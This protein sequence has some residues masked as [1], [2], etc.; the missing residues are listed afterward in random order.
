M[1]DVNATE[2]TAI[3]TA[4]TQTGMA[5]SF[6]SNLMADVAEQGYWAS[7]EVN[8]MEE[9]KVLYAARHDNLMLKDHMGEIIELAGIVL[10]TQ[11]INDPTVGAKIVPCVHLI[12]TDGKV[13]Q[14]A[15]GGVVNSACDIISDF[16]LPETWGD[17][18]VSVAC[19]EITTNSGNR[20]KY[21]TV[22]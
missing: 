2:T 11:T 7:F 20:Y 13:Y 21:L 17:E 15:S 10:D 1:T 18:P 12:A 19:K 5:V 16:G 4:N 9:K 22:L 8:T 6:M 3:A 14:S